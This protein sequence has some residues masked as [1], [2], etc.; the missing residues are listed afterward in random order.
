MG[1]A[2]FGVQAFLF[3]ECK[4]FYFFSVSWSSRQIK[5]GGQHVST[6]SNGELQS[7]GTCDVIPQNYEQLS[8]IERKRIVPMRIPVM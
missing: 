4:L 1:K 6:R 3:L 7:Y 2:T 8:N 5:G